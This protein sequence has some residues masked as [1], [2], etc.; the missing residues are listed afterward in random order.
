M[1]LKRKAVGAIPGSRSCASLPG[2]CD[3][4]EKHFSISLFCY[5]YQQGSKSEQDKQEIKRLKICMPSITSSAG[6]SSLA[7]ISI[8]HFLNQSKQAI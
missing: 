2:K 1:F 6:S 5:I 7:R 8:L 4:G 3:D